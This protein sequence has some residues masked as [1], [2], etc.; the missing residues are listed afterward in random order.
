MKYVFK[1]TICA[2]TA[3]IVMSGC[4][5]DLVRQENKE[6]LLESSKQWYVYKIL[7]QNGREFTPIWEQAKSSMSF[8]V[9]ENRIFGVSVC[10]NYFATFAL[11][12][13]KLKVSNSGS[14]RRICFPH[15]SAEYEYYFLKALEGD[16]IVRKKGNQMQLEGKEATYY[17]K[18]IED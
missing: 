4:F 17:L 18:L 6:A 1:I 3:L 7:Y 11:S 14:S 8:D 12:G 9:D 15:E 5:V 10:N 16:F 2:M 13:K